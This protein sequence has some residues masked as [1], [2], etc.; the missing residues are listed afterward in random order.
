MLLL[1]EVSL[2]FIIVKNFFFYHDIVTSTDYIHILNLYAFNS[3]PS[4]TLASSNME[5]HVIMGLQFEKHLLKFFQVGRAVY[6]QWA[7]RSLPPLDFGCGVC[8]MNMYR[9]IVQWCQRCWR[10]A[11]KSICWHRDNSMRN[12]FA[13]ISSHISLIWN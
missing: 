13:S 10:I 4:N 2:A 8:S 7:A 3:I 5:H 1:Q 12:V 9:S 11:P 6:L